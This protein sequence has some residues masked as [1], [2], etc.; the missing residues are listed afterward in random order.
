MR[1]L[2]APRELRNFS[3]VCE[4][5]ERSRIGRRGPLTTTP[6][7]WTRRGCLQVSLSSH[8]CEERPKR[9]SQERKTQTVNRLLN[10]ELELKRGALTELCRKYRVARLDL[11]SSGAT[12]DWHS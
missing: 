11:F 10:A 4:F 9:S 8:C 2:W 5:S 1:R 12:E 3:T 7:R 6:W